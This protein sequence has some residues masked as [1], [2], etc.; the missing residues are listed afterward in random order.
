M[1]SFIQ[2]KYSNNGKRKP[3]GIGGS[4]ASNVDALE[5]NP[6]K[7]GGAKLCVLT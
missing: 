6:G 5:A 3:T 4:C 7:P 1:I 2:D